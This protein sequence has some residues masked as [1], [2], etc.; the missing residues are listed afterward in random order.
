MILLAYPH[1]QRGKRAID[2]ARESLHRETM[3]V[4]R[5]H[6]EAHPELYRKLKFHQMP[7]AEQPEHTPDLPWKV[8]RH[9]CTLPFVSLPWAA[10][11]RLARAHDV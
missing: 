6:K 3:A 10:D 2:Y 4:F 9:G 8:H 7:R 11:D 5:V 1:A